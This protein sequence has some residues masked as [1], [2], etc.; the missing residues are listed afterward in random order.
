MPPQPT[1]QTDPNSPDPSDSVKPRL[2]PGSDAQK[3]N[4]PASPQEQ[5]DLQQCLTKAGMMIHGRSS[6]N[7]TLNSLHAPNME[8]SQAVGKTAAQILMTINQ[9]KA[10]TTGAPLSDE[11]MREAAR[12]VIPELMDVGIA[13]GIFPIKPPPGGAD[14]PGSGSDQYNKQV[15]MAMLE[16]TKIYGEDK[17]RS[18]QHAQLTE[19]AQNDWAQNVQHEVAS[20]T[21]DPKFMAR[22]RAGQQPNGAPTPQLVPGASQQGSQLEPPPTSPPGGTPA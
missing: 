18:P 9:Q 11:I 22:V 15:R 6:R 21:A 14:A 2:I 13:A 10:A 17:L 5:R 16:A 8:V 3:G 1:D 19:Q 7:E 12:Y 20:G 4:V